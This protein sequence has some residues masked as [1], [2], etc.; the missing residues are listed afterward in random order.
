MNPRQDLLNVPAFKMSAEINRPHDF[1]DWLQINHSIDDK[2]ESWPF[3]PRELYGQYLHSKI[4]NYIGRELTHVQ[5]RLK[6]IKRYGHSYQLSLDNGEWLS[7]DRI[8]LCTGYVPAPALPVSSASDQTRSRQVLIVGSG[9]AAID[10]WRQSR[11]EP[12]TQITFLSLHGLFPLPH[13]IKPNPVQLPNFVGLSPLRI[14][15]MSRFF[16]GA[17]MREWADL[18]DALRVQASDI[19]KHWSTQE[20]A[21]FLRHLRA[22]WELIRH[23][24]PLPIHQ[25]LSRDFE[26]GR[27]KIIKGRLIKKEAGNE[28]S[29]WYLPK[30]QSS[31]VSGSFD[32]VLDATGAR[33]DQ[34]LVSNGNKIEGLK[35]CEFGFGLVNESAPSLWIVGPASK[36]T[37]W[38]STAITEIRLQAEQTAQKI[39]DTADEKLNFLVEKWLFHPRQLG[40]TYFEHFCFAWSLIG[41]LCK[42]S[43][44]LALH[45]LLPSLL[46]DYA[47]QEIKALEKRLSSTE[48]KLSRR[49]KTQTTQAAQKPELKKVS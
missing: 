35:P 6:N 16:R 46:T 42:I 49:K 2:F 43:L 25:E 19:W 37:E 40:L 26:L 44:A 27:V 11:K 39:V 28:G 21:Q 31:A 12:Q 13:L 3:V 18:A 34:S 7:A 33:I 23:R 1:C 24:V 32:L 36:A 20:R 14:L 5:G 15:Q 45:S 8:V 38:E 9:L 22:Y 41:R 10:F 48:R 47:T 30:G 4:K 29:V 17:G